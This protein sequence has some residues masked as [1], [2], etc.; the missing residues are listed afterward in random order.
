MTS[1]KRC[2]R[3]SERRKRRRRGPDGIIP[4]SG[5]GPGLLPG[6][7]SPKRDMSTR[8]RKQSGVPPK[9]HTRKTLF[10]PRKR[11]L[12][13]RGLQSVRLSPSNLLPIPNRPEYHRQTSDRFDGRQVNEQSPVNAPLSSL[14]FRARRVP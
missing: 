1:R 7:F 14:S 2:G 8:L 3:S 12:F 6:P 11:Q 4:P 13:A 10:S 9:Q 5:E